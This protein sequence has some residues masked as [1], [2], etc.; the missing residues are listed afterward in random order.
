MPI[1]RKTSCFKAMLTGFIHTSEQKYQTTCILILQKS[2]FCQESVHFN[3][4]IPM[5]NA[6]PRL[7]ACSHA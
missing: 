2:S 1:S 4:E 5:P 7:L 6:Q 3:I